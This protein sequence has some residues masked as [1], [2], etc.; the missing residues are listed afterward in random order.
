MPDGCVVL[1]IEIRWVVEVAA[2]ELVVA[3]VVVAAVELVV[4]QG[5]LLTVDV[6]CLL[7]TTNFFCCWCMIL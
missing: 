2:V 7:T 1:R 6:A 4:A 3:V 5:C